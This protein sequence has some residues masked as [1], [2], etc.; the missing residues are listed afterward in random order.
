MKT[1][2]VS[3]CAMW[4]ALAAE[5]ASPRLLPHSSALLPIVCGVMFWTRSTPGLM[6]CGLVLLLDW[7]ARPSYLPLC[8]MVLPFLAVIF[9]APSIQNDEYQSRKS[10]L[11]IP[12]PLQLPLLT[13][14]AVVLQTIGSLNW[15]QLSAPADAVTE[16]TEIMKSPLLLA[17]PLSAMLSLLIRMADELGMRRSY[18]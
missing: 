15:A 4:V 9:L 8:P 13:L 1:L 18:S 5:L 2:F 10:S 3:A 16:I 6:L 17:L 12:A 7:I 14:A 11:K